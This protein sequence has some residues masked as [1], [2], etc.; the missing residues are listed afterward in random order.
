MTVGDRGGTLFSQK[1][2]TKE[3]EARLRHL[4]ERDVAN[5]YIRTEWFVHNTLDG[6][7]VLTVRD[8]DTSHAVQVALNDFDLFGSEYNPFA[9]AHR[10]LVHRLK[11]GIVPR[12]KAAEVGD[13]NVSANG[14][15][16]TRTEDGWRLTHHLIAEKELGRRLDASEQVR[17]K[18][19]DKTNLSPDN[20][21]VI[22][23]GKTSVRRRLA[24]I[25][26]QIQELTAERDLLVKELEDS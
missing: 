23:K 5:I 19:N 10:G 15:H 11:E 6:V 18:D 20:V 24:R 1:K 3:T 17:F 4:H 13:T 25:E 26:A 21:Q 16:Y 14:Y 12:G 8:I 7:C 22:K 2:W 9:P